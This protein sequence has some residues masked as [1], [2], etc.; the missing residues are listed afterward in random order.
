MHCRH[1][2]PVTASQHGAQSAAAALTDV[3]HQVPRLLEVLPQDSRKALSAASKNLREM[4]HS[5]VTVEHLEDIALL[6]KGSWPHLSMV[7]LPKQRDAHPDVE[8]LRHRWQLLAC[9][10]LGE[11]R[12]GLGTTDVA[13]LLSSQQPR[14]TTLDSRELAVKPLEHLLSSKWSESQS[15]SL[16][17]VQETVVGTAVMAQLSKGRWQCLSHFELCSKQ[18]DIASILLLFKSKWA[19]A[20]ADV[21]QP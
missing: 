6:A 17:Q 19:P 18:L 14:Y 20:Q 21:Q 7:I 9:V 12:F 11:R 5:L 4:F 13:I 10:S 8:A 15:L 3:L 2:V 16:H 1:I